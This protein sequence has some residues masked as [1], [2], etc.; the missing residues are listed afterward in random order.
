MRSQATGECLAA[1]ANRASSPP[2]PE[3]D[4]LGGA[5]GP[6]WSREDGGMEKSMGGNTGKDPSV[7]EKSEGARTGKGQ[8]GAKSK[9]CTL[10]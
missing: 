1:T 3:K 8:Q 7:G 9:S 5:G 10:L 2:P 4:A 6:T